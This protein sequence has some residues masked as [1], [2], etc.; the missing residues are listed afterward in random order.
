MNYD[1]TEMIKLLDAETISALL[2]IYNLKYKHIAI[3]FNCTKEN[4]VY[5]M[6]HDRFKDYQREIILELFQ[7]Q[8]L[9]VTELIL[10][11]HMANKSKKKGGIS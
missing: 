7:L 9:E 8:G 5:L 6:K 3:R 10:I 1:K 2:R 4:I 11:H